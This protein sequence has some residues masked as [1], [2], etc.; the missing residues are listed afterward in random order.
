MNN[1]WNQYIMTRNGRSAAD[2]VP[3]RPR[4]CGKERNVINALEQFQRTHSLVG[5]SMLR[6]IEDARN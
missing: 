1:Q 6:L 3:F 4:Y 2:L 5:I